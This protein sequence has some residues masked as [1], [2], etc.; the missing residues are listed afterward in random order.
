MPA[1][2]PS[3]EPLVVFENVSKRYPNGQLALDNVSLTFQPGEFVVIVGLSGAGKSTLIRCL[4]RLVSPTEG[5]ILI[6]GQDIVTAGDADLRKAR[7]RIGMI[8][9]NYN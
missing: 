5:R 9:Q 8:F 6:D 2:R 7:A 1:E 3:L 4:N